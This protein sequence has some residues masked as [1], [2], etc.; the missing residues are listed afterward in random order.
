MKPMLARI[1]FFRVHSRWL[2]HLGGGRILALLLALCLGAPGLQAQLPPNGDMRPT[3]AVDAGTAPPTW[4]LTW[5]GRSG[6]RY[7][8]WTTPDLMS[9]W[10]QL[11]FFTATGADTE[12]GVGFTVSGPMLFFRVHEYHPRAITTLTDS[13]ADG[14]PDIWEIAHFGDLSAN[15]AGDP[16]SDGLNNASEFHRGSNPTRQPDLSLA[17][18]LALRIAQPLP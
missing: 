4:T 5:W 9:S 3:L 8:V 16:D 12:T 7:V 1:D 17:A 14:L 10:T 18:S 13:D 11:P 15:S 6:F 2:R